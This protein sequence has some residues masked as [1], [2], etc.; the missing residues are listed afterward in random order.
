MSK[1]AASHVNPQGPGDARPTALQ[2]IEDEG[3]I[4][5]LTGKVVLV[6]GANAGIGLETA[7]AIH[8]TGATLVLTARDSTKAQQA[9]DNVKN[10]PGPKSGAPIHAIELRLDSLVS[11]RSAARAF[12]AKSDKLNVLILNA[13]VMATPQGKTED[14][15]ETQFG[16]NYLGHFLLFQLLKPA[17]LSASTPEFQSRVISLSSMGHRA[18]GIHLDDLNFEKEPYEPW[19]AYGRSKTANIYLANEIERRY[20][21][22]GLH[23]LSVH[24]GVIDTNLTQF[25]PEEVV[26]NFFKKD[27]ALQKVMKSIPQGAA[28]TVYAALSKEWEGRGG[29]FLNN[30]AEEK[31]AK[32]DE[33][34][35]QNPVGYAPWAYDVESASKLWEESNTLV[36]ANDE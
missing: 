7:R 17:L 28:T 33:D 10:G 27:E 18:S 34:W 31:P 9:I 19:T 12:F 29:K 25:L 1:Y 3:L 22:K 14:G 20:G 11:V 21:S 6:T 24:P 4:G 30:L 35:M 5:K 8:A 32:P 26:D 2:V 23:A 16:T 36:G 13:G 15:F